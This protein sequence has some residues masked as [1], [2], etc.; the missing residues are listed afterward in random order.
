MESDLDLREQVHRIYGQ[1]AAAPEAEHPFR[2]GR[3]V[4]LRAGYPPEW[5]A[6]VPAASID[7]F[8]GLSCLP[9][10]AQVPADAA[11]LDLGCGAGLDAL[12]MA[13][14]VASVVGID[15][16]TEMLASASASARTMGIENVEFRLGD[17]ERIPAESSAFGAALVNGI[18]NLNPARA[19]IFDQLARVIKPG[20]VLWAAELI[21]KGPLPPDVKPSREDWFS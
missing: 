8:A 11:L 12:L 20:G 6:G 9:C 14:R 2:I 19:A 21:L 18:F 10:L 13:S 5:L 4:A 3:E 7:A 15:F 16:S 1:V 17:A